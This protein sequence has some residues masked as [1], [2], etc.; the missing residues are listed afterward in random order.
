MEIDMTKVVRLRVGELLR[1]RNMSSADL[2][3][4]AKIAPLTAR[5]LAKGR[6]ERVDLVVMGKICEVLDVAPGD[7]F[8]LT[9]ET[10][11]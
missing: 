11:V 1:E 7:L 3:E 4:K 6:T 5:N 9:E 2:S 8:Y 10:A